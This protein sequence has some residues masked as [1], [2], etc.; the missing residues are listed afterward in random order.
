MALPLL[1]VLDDYQGVALS[2][3]DWTDVARRYNISVLSE[4]IA[5]AQTLITALQDS[6]VVVAMRERTPFPAHVIKHLPRLRLLVTTG[7]VNSSIDLEG[8]RAADVVVYGTR[9]SSSS[10]TELTLGMVIALS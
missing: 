7:P 9:G 10:V 8:T 5:D 1:T 2:S 3:A 6:E 4:H